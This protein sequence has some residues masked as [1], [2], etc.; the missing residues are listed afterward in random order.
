MCHL[1]RKTPRRV[2]YL[3]NKEVFE[4]EAHRLRPTLVKYAFSILHSEEDAEDVVQETFLKMWFFRERLEEYSS[5]DAVAYVITARQ[6]INRLRGRKT[7]LSFSEA[8]QIVDESTVP[9]DE[10]IYDSL[11]AAIDTLP[12]TEQ[13][14]MRMKHIEGMETEEIATLISSNPSAVRTALS[15]AR[16]KLRNKFLSGKS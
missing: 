15:R 5:I 3:M 16:K 2:R 1:G 6:A 10:S 4:I 13:A 8:I 9:P 12:T 7:A 14:V 11:L